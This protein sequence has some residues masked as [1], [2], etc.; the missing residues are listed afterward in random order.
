MPTHFRPDE[1]PIVQFDPLL[2]VS[3]FALFRRLREERAPKLIDVRRE[4]G[5]RTLRGALVWE[6]EKWRPGE[7]EE[8]VFFDEDGSEALP[9]VAKLQHEGFSLARMLFGGLDLYEFSLDPEVVG[10]DTFLELSR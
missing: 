10:D 2:E 4:P 6:G 9:I 1:K 5:K 3:P 8:V 7:G